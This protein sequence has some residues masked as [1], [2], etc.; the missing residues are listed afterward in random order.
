M[1]LNPV[2]LKFGRRKLGLIDDNIEGAYQNDFSTRYTNAPVQGRA[3]GSVGDHNFDGLN[4]FSVSIWLKLDN[5]LGLHVFTGNNE[6]GTGSFE[7]WEMLS[8]GTDILFFLISSF[9][10]DAIRIDST[11]SV[12]SAGVWHHVVVTFSAAGQDESDLTMYLDG[13]SITHTAVAN[14]LSTAI[15]SSSPF[16]V[17]HRV[18]TFQF[19]YLGLIDEHSIWSTEL[20]AAEVTEIYN[21]GTP[22]NL[23]VHSE[24]ANLD[25]WYRMGDENQFPTIPDQIGSADLTMVNLSAGAFDSDVPP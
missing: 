13:S 20:S 19:P 7:G 23:L 5:V 15:S 12:L 9:P 1:N 2:D 11:G 17:G 24:I 8:F 4:P 3:E 16:A 10:T 22:A 25:S 21:G 18:S 6:A 14:T